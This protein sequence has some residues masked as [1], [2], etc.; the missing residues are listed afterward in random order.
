MQFLRCIVYRLGQPKWDFWLWI[1][2]RTHCRNL[3][4]FLSVWFYVKSIL[5]DFRRSKTAVLTILE[6]MNFEFWQFFTLENVKSVQKSKIQTCSNGQNGSF[7]GCNWPKLISHEMWVGEKLLNF[8]IVYSQ[9]GCQ[10][11]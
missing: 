8:H 7:W 2:H 3:A 11:L 6:A 10:V 9:L 1:F 4:I 5:A